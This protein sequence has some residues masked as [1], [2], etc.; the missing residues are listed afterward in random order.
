MYS[1]MGFGCLRFPGNDTVNRNCLHDCVDLPYLTHLLL[2]HSHP[3]FRL[4][5]TVSLLVSSRSNHYSDLAEPVAV[6]P[7]HTVYTR[8][9]RPQSWRRT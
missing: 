1:D 3:T 8:G 7:N 2:T 6:S 5:M 4:R 9:R